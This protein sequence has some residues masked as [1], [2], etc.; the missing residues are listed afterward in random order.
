MKLELI[1]TVFSHS[2]FVI[3]ENIKDPLE[4]QIV[5]IVHDGLGGLVIYR[6]L[7]VDPKMIVALLPFRLGDRYKVYDCKVLVDKNESDSVT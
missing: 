3:D 6:H 1:N 2:F 4:G 5:A 7:S